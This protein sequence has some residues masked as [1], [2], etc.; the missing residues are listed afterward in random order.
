[1]SNNH[2]LDLMGTY[3][4]LRSD[5]S[6][7]ALPV[8]DDFWTRLG[9]GE[10]GSFHH[11]Y[12]LSC[13]HYTQSWTH[14]EMHPAGDEIVCLLSGRVELVLAQEDGER[15]HTLDQAGSFVVVPRGTWHTARLQGPAQMLFITPGEGTQH[16]PVALSA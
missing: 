1:M 16:R 8:G 2:S 10:L 15:S 3:V 5:L 12:L 4:R 7:E 14:W 13:Q 9:Q 11:E 6:S